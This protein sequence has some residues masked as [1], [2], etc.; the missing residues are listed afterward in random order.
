MKYYLVMVQNG[1]TQAIYEKADYDDA[2]SAFHS[3]LAY[4]HESRTSTMC[5]II[6]G[7]GNVYKREMWP[8]NE[9][10]ES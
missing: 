7:N 9:G 10:G 4:R 2:L 6:D 1:N 3:E 5:M 8:M